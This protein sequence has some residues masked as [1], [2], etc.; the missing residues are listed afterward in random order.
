MLTIKNISLSFDRP[1]LDGISFEVKPGKIVGLVGKSGA[2]KTSLLKI[3]GGLLDA[4]EG[5]VF[6]NDRPVVGPK[7]RLIPGDKD[8][9]LVNQ[10]FGL[11]TF[12]T[13]ASN[14]YERMH[15]LPKDVQ[16]IFTTE[17]LQLLEIEHLRNQEARL[18]SGGEQQRLAIARALACE[19]D[20]ILLDEPFVHLDTRL[21]TKV[22]NYLLELRKVRNT[23]IILVSHDGGEVLGLS[24]EVI[25]LK[26]GKIKRKAKP[27]SAYYNYKTIEEGENYGWVNS[28][29]LE[30][31]RIHFRPDEYSI[32]GNTDELL[33]EWLDSTFAAGQYVN[34]FKSA[35]KKIVVLTSNEPLTDV[36]KIYIRR[37]DS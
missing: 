12:Q 21:K 25:Y 2:G 35:G 10:D 7:D 30:G 5:E 19:P 20:V 3:I 36:R 8:I 28:V 29:E 33:V 15:Y 31:K 22:T 37:K 23:S 4:S 6:L 9:Q 16:K 24:D 26:D 1:I 18:L 14:L 13:V 17:L 11:N 34:H 32:V 27:Q